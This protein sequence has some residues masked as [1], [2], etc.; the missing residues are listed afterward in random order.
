M[1]INQISI[2]QDE[3]YKDFAGFKQSIGIKYDRNILFKMTKIHRIKDYSWVK[4]NDIWSYNSIIYDRFSRY[5]FHYLYYFT[6]YVFKNEPKSR[7]ISL[8]LT[9]NKKTNETTKR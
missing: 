5:E 2:V 4:I 1:K 8:A 6:C 7:L 3:V 9:A